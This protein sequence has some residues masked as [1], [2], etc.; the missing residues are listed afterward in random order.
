[1]PKNSLDYKHNHENK[2]NHEKKSSKIETKERNMFNKTANKGKRVFSKITKKLARKN[3]LKQIE[4]QDETYESHP[5]MSRL[6]KNSENQKHHQS[7][8]DSDTDMESEHPIESS[9]KVES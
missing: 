9:Q 3:S 8:T 5:N 1:M 4:N 6:R 7:L 2:S